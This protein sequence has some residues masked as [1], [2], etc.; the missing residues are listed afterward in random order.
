MTHS[1]V[2]PAAKTASRHKR[3][4]GRIVHVVVGVWQRPRL[5]ALAAP[6]MLATLPPEVTFRCR[7]LEQHVTC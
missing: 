7:R 2:S 1:N 6:V 5:H 3:D 4:F